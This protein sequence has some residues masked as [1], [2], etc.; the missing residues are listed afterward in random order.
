MQ[1]SRYIQIND[2]CLI[3][4]FYNTENN[5]NLVYFDQAE[6][7][8]DIVHNDITDEYS[9]INRNATMPSAKDKAPKFIFSDYV[10][11]AIPVNK[12]KSLWAW[13]KRD[14]GTGHSDIWN[15]PYDPSDE[16][17]IVVKEG[18]EYVNRLSV[19]QSGT[20]NLNDIYYDRVRLHIMT[21]YSLEGLD[22]IVLELTFDECSGRAFPASQF[23][24][25][26]AITGMS[27]TRSTSPLSFSQKSYDKYIEFYV[28]SLAQVNKE[29]WGNTAE[30]DSVDKG[31]Y[32]GSK[33]KTTDD[34]IFGVVYSHPMPRL[35][36]NENNYGAGFINKSPITF[37]LYELTDMY[38]KHDC[39]FYYVKNKF[40]ASIKSSDEYNLLTCTIKEATDGDYFEYY[41]MWDGGFIKDYID[42]LNTFSGHPLDDPAWVVL[43]Q[44]TVYERVGFSDKKTQEFSTYQTD[45]F[46]KPAMFRPILK[47]ASSAV[48]ANIVY[49]MKLVNT[50]TNESIVRMA[51]AGIPFANITKY[52]KSMLKINVNSGSKAVNVFNKVIN[53]KR[54]PNDLESDAEAWSRA[55]SRANGSASSS[56]S[57]ITNGSSTNGGSSS[58]N[59]LDNNNISFE[60]Y[61]DRNNIALNLNDTRVENGVQFF[62][63]SQLTIFLSGVSDNVFKFN[64]YELRGY[65][66]YKKELNSTSGDY[67]KKFFMTFALDNNDKKEFECIFNPDESSDKVCSFT[68]KISE[69]D[70]VKILAQ[71]KD[72]NFYIVEHVIDKDGNTLSTSLVYTGMWKNV[73]DRSA[74]LYTYNETLIE[75]ITRK[76]K[77]IEEREAA[78]DKREQEL[79]DYRKQLDDFAENLNSLYAAIKAATEKSDD[80]NLQ[81]VADALGGGSLSAPTFGK[82]DDKNKN[83]GNE[84]A[85]N[86]SFTDN[87]KNTSSDND[88]DKDSGEQLTEGNK[89][90]C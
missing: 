59:R 10:K 2:W 49:I 6:Q 18:N 30:V 81:S 54:I 23:F 84:S 74:N 75:W 87:K 14:T 80:P 33:K 83:K 1:T 45:N 66:F 35:D 64:A 26:K 21:G 13:A 43:N 63:Q 8:T 12:Q 41:P 46:D 86:S 7:P 52:G 47:Y 9:F 71:T 44:I 20:S 32:S 3:E 78:L 40:T 37:N 82:G 77:E 89:T 11:S 62:G 25:S 73:A 19:D 5:G 34:E 29:Y 27:V 70:S 51:T 28:P 15:Y 50:N 90:S 79:N 38:K 36:K 16:A 4:Y 17:Q 22:G 69:K 39:Y 60:H 48:T 55:I 85:T 68:A 67:A 42:T 65:E 56:Y 76:L 24:Y 31:D 53:I 61:I 72:T 57:D 88:K 58:T